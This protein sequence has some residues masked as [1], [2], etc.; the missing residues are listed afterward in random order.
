MT[1]KDVILL[2]LLVMLSTLSLSHAGQFEKG[3]HV[4]SQW[5]TSCKKCHNKTSTVQI[6]ARDKVCGKFRG[7]KICLEDLLKQ[8][9]SGKAG[10]DEKDTLAL[11]IKMPFPDYF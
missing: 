3:D 10:A 6:E 1:H 4:D 9:V 11:H 5:G 7:W 2:V 8:Q